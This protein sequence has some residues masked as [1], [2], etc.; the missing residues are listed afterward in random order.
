LSAQEPATLWSFDIAGDP[1]ITITG[2]TSGFTAGGAASA[3]TF[4]SFDYSIVCTGCGHG[5]SHPL[6]GPIDF[7]VDNTLI[8][9]FTTNSH[10]VYFTSDIVGT[11]WRSGNVAGESVARSA[12]PE[13][14]S[15]LLVGTGL[16]G[17]GLLRRGDFP[18]GGFGPER[19][20]AGSC[21]HGFKSHD[22]ARTD[23]APSR[24]GTDPFWAAPSLSRF[25]SS[26]LN[27]GRQQADGPLAAKG[28]Y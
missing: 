17:L 7:T 26:F 28:S 25:G 9:A 4:G 11:Q 13:P 22:T 2:L 1:S 27:R 8:A 24:L 16:I 23:A 10:G 15:F 18:P 19:M 3:S 5:D 21:G 6:P 14:F 12:A 20:K